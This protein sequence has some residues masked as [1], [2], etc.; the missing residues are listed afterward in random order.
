MVL[1]CPAHYYVR[2]RVGSSG[3]ISK[4]SLGTQHL[5]HAVIMHAAV[6][7]AAPF[8]S[9]WCCVCRHRVSKDGIGWN[10]AAN[11]GM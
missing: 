11:L 7:L 9:V 4:S 2:Q 3:A 1:A 5:S 10:T 6:A 8:A